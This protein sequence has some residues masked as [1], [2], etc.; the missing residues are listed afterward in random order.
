MPE[1]PP[2]KP[3][4][5]AVAA[6]MRELEDDI[7]SLCNMAMI[8]GDLLDHDLSEY[9]G[10][11]VRSMPEPGKTM[12]VVLG[13][14]Q[15]EVLSFAWSDVINRAIRLRNRWNDALDGKAVAA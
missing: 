10:G 5:A 2:G 13:Y 9:S 8:L 3:D 11:R 14:Q 7:Y 12:T 15:M 6:A 4:D 1:A